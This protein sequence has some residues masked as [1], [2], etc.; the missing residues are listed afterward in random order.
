MKPF[1]VFV[2]VI[3]LMVGSGA[4][5]GAEEESSSLRLM[6]YNIHHGAGVDKKLDLGRI[7]ELIA[8]ESLDLVALQEV[9]S[10]CKRSKSVDQAAELGQLTGMHHAFGKFMDFQGGE[11]GLAVLSRFPILE[12]IRHQL[13]EGAE[14]RCALEVQVEVPGMETP[15]S[16]VSIHHDWTDPEFRLAQVKTLLEALK[17]RHHPVILAG[18]FNGER[19]DP[20][21]QLLA[22]EGWTIVEKNAGT[23]SKTFPSRE[24]RVEIDFFVIKG[25]FEAK[26]DHTVMEEEVASDHRPIRAVIEFGGS[27]P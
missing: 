13:P 18:D 15:V 23:G 24:P 4:P 1:C 9:D 11:Y 5:V 3:T 10:V 22:D 7:G 12:T 26:V 21:M 20:S 14:P 8:G 19:T 6:A 17:D 27:A 25:F 2:A 16:F